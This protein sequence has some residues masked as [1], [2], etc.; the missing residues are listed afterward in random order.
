M[1]NTYAFRGAALRALALTADLRATSANVRLLVLKVLILLAR[2]P[3]N[4]LP[5][6]CFCE[7][8]QA[9]IATA[10][11]FSFGQKKMYELFRSKCTNKT[12]NYKGY[13][14]VSEI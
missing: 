2:M 4:A 14:V 8:L 1:N 13:A 5:T 12:T 9:T 11:P 3:K 7:R 6:L 10:A